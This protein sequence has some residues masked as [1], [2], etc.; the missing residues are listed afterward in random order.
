MIAGSKSAMTISYCACCRCQ[1]AHPGVQSVG[2][3]N[4]SLRFFAEFGHI[5]NRNFED[6]PVVLCTSCPLKASSSIIHQQVSVF[7]LVFAISYYGA[8]LTLYSCFKNCSHWAVC[9]CRLSAK[10][11]PK[12]S[13]VCVLP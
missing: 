10:K 13:R 4:I 12:V 9:F 8:P 3:L 7:K 6:L 5:P 1:R 2:M 11:M